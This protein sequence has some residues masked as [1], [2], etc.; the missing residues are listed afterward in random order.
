MLNQNSRLTRITTRLKLQIT[1]QENLIEDNTW[2]IRQEDVL[3]YINSIHPI[4]CTL[5]LLFDGQNITKMTKRLA[6]RS[7]VRCDLIHGVTVKL[8]VHALEDYC[9]LI[10]ATQENSELTS[11]KE[12]T[13]TLTSNVPHLDINHSNSSMSALDRYYLFSSGVRWRVLFEFSTW[14]L[15]RSS[16]IISFH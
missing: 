15:D 6:F 13:S 3:V 9:S 8:P 4:K 2:G 12:T 14:M 5:T 11:I 1:K 7:V 16:T 10:C